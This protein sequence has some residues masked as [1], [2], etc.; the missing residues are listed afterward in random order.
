MENKMVEALDFLYKNLFPTGINP[1]VIYNEGWMTRLLV[2]QSIQ[3][4][5]IFVLDNTIIDF[6]KL[7]NWSS[8]ALIKSPFVGIPQKPEGY[9]HAD[10][11]LGDFQIDYANSGAISVCEEAK[12][13]GIIEAKMGSNLSQRT[14]NATKYNQASRSI[15]CLA[16]QVPNRCEIF[17]VVVAPQATITRHNISQQVKPATIISE[18][19]DRFLKSNVTEFKF[20]RVSKTGKKTVVK[21]KEEIIKKVSKSKILTISYENWID[22]LEK[23]ENMKSMKDFYD[24]CKEYNKL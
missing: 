3:E 8:E 19:E 17:F 16:S 11:I 20:K 9:T 18:I 24:K 6:G 14:T 5:L 4:K 12:V 21:T 10:I 15:C 1:T 13:L 22:K 7:S 2:K 23:K